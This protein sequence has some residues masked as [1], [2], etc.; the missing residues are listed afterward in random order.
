MDAKRRV[1]LEVFEN[2][3]LRRIYGGKDMKRLWRKKT[4]EML[5][6][7]G[8]SS[9]NGMARTQKWDG[10]NSDEDGGG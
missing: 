10:W 5:E 4:N 3:V 1:T 2:K 7:Y 9:V 6:Q 8:K